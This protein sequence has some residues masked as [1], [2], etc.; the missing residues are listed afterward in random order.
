MKLAATV[1]GVH[2]IAFFTYLPL[3]SILDTGMT[4]VWH[5]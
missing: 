3:F 4:Y 2:V 5:H 1:I